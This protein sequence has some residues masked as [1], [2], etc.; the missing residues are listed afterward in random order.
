MDRNFVQATTAVINK[1][2]A[3]AG[4]IKKN[5]SGNVMTF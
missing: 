5:Q 3:G 4:K 2:K 1:E